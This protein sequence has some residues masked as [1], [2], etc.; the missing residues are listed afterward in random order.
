[1]RKALY[2]YVFILLSLTG[3]AQAQS[4]AAVDT[5]QTTQTTA[6]KEQQPEPVSAPEN[7]PTPAADEKPAEMADTMRA[8]GK[9]YVVVLVLATIFAG[10]IIYLIRLDR[11]ITKFEKN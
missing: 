7:Q 8:N 6:A 10:I 4:A 5:V 11:K 2:L 3:L 9:I 1:M